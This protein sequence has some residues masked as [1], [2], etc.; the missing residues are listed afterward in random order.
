MVRT[1]A[2]LWLIMFGDWNRSRKFFIVQ[3]FIRVFVHLRS[4]DTNEKF[5][6]QQKVNT[7]PIIQSLRQEIAWTSVQ[8]KTHGVL[9]SQKSCSDR[10]NNILM[11][12]P[13][14]NFAERH[15]R[16]GIIGTRISMFQGRK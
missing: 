4:T 6:L 16:V 11:M 14:Q 10:K 3:H 13:H 8:S 5:Y 12:K 2:K 9:Q 7:A 15:R 1:P